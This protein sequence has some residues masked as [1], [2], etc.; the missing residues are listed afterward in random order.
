MLS[1]RERAAGATMTI[2]QR[3]FRESSRRSTTSV[4]GVS[5]RPRER[6]DVT[7]VGKSR[8][9]RHGALEAQ[10]ESRVRH[11]AVAAQVAIPAVMLLV[12][13]GG[14]EPRVQHIEA[15]L[16]LAA[17]D[18]LADAGRQHVH[19]RDSPAVVVDAHVERL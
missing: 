7:Y 2:E 16:A 10:A 3:V 18:D 12:E 8:G 19:R 4:T 1:E 11:R 13:L 15:L 14:G 17:A 6:N 5:R 9:V